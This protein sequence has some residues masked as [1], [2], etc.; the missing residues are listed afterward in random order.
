MGIFKKK[1]KA[2][3]AQKED[4]KKQETAAS[5]PVPQP[6][7]PKHAASDAVPK[8]T[9]SGIN[10]RR[11]S[12]EASDYASSSATFQ[13]PLANNVNHPFAQ[14]QNTF[15]SPSTPLAPYR[16]FNGGFNGV[17]RNQ[18]AEVFTTDPDAPPLPTATSTYSTPGQREGL[19]RSGSG[20]FND[21][22]T[23]R[24]YDNAAVANPNPKMAAATRD[25]IYVDPH[26]SADSGYGSEGHS[27]APSEQGYGH[28]T[29]RPHLLQDTG[30]FLPELSLSDELAKEPAWSE[31]SFGGDS[32]AITPRAV[33]DRNQDKGYFSHLDPVSTQRSAK[34]KASKSSSKQARFDGGQSNT[35]VTQQ[36]QEA[37]LSRKESRTSPQSNYLPEPVQEDARP[38]SS[39]LPQ[40]DHA[41]QAR[42]TTPPPENYEEPRPS[43]AAPVRH[44]TPPPQRLP[45]PQPQ[46]T[47]PARMSTPPPA[48]DREPS[49]QQQSMPPAR[50]FSPPPMHQA[51]GFA[52]LERFVSQ[53]SSVPAHGS[54]EG[55][56]V[57]KRGKILDE[58][59]EVVGELVE[60][61]IIDCVR[62]RCNAYGEVLSTLR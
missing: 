20:Y 23:H 41:H 45:E 54:L 60:G 12:K 62:Q 56:K 52:P 29:P 58:E 18:S 7:K 51:Q 37:R 11:L 2:E 55:Y 3:K 17:Q 53:R 30:S 31:A 44:S 39:T 14:A 22:G 32:P 40:T 36:Q 27:R 15:R 5:K 38:E 42:S 35:V 24:P 19:P 25:R 48:H 46:Y 61:D 1:S 34:P 21:R 43:Y 47:L 33:D 16:G 13:H 9:P 6:Y 28:E 26:H 50:A 10:G 4:G 49:I 57:N 59:G 8:P